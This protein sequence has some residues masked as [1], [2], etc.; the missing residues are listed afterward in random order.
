MG[1]FISGGVAGLESNC[2]GEWLKN[3][4][5]GHNEFA[6]GGILLMLLG[7]I[8]VYLRALPERAWEWF[9]D[10]LMM[11]VTVKDDDAGF[12]WAKEWLLE[13]HFL[14]RIRRVD[15]DTSLRS[16]ELALLPA[17]GSHWFWH[18]GR[19]FQVSLYRSENKQARSERRDELLTF[20]T[21]GRRREILYQFVRE[22]ADCHQRR[23][24][25]KSHLFVRDDDYW[26]RVR[27]YTPRAIDSVILKPGQ[28]DDLL[29]DIEEFSRARERYRQLGIPYHRGYLLHGPPGTGKTSLI[30]AVAGKFAMS[31]YAINL[32]EFNDKTLMR[33]IHEV[34]PGSAILFEDIDCI[35]MAEA[36]PN[37]AREKS[38]NG[39]EEKADALANFG[40]TLSGLLN[41]LDGFYAPENMLFF[42][43]TNRPEVLDA[44]LLRPGRIDYRLCL[45]EADYSQKIELYRRFFPEHSLDDA[46]DFV[47]AHPEAETMA[48][49]Q[50]L[51]LE[52]VGRPS[53]GKDF[54]TVSIALNRE[55]ME[56]RQTGDSDTRS[57]GGV[58]ESTANT[59][60]G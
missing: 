47:E 40:V 37:A 22:V 36:R 25:A 32:T 45:G 31:I 48:E 2:M 30:S 19:P 24:R 28:K 16:D 44:A 34:P 29:D 14:K 4:L 11:S 26:T 58:V 9:A 42:M 27:G 46:T 54:V 56:V 10:Q 12:V 52:A 15:L 57:Q 43:T 7:G 3:I 6:S 51:L 53:M 17:P 35:K 23:Q 39:G 8:G 5:S 59:C 50:G 60:C 49:Y 13:Q 21:F 38:K 55:E 41:V 18:R 20:R 33:A 1:A